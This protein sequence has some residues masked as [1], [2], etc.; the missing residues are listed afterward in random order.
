MSDVPLVMNSD[1]AHREAD[2]LEIALQLG[3]FQAGFLGQTAHELRSPMSQ[4]MSL[5]Q[6]IL[7]DLCEDPA[8]ER[9]FIAQCYAASQKFMT[10]LDLVV[11]VSKLDYGTT[12]FKRKPFDLLSLMQ[13]LAML[14]TVKANNRNLKLVIAHPSVTSLEIPGDRHYLQHL[15]I[16]LLNTTIQQTETGRIHFDY[17][18]TPEQT[19]TLQLR[20]PQSI[21]FWEISTLQKLTLSN[22][23]TPAEVKQLAQGF[24]F[25][26]QLKWQLCQKLVLTMGGTLTRTH[27]ADTIQV[28]GQLPLGNN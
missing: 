24:E 10:L 20:S 23:P 7:A 26:P 12:T 3:Q 8:E 9:E 17:A 14:F 6:L 27:T 25:S 21:D 4:I 11:E 13:E 18:V 15:F 19:L 22:R 1:L 28:R 2:L 16:T 5:Q